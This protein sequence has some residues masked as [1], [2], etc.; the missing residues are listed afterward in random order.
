MQAYAREAL[1]AAAFGLQVPADRAR[2]RAISNL[3]AVSSASQ[4][5]G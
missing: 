4:M 2:E 1:A 5:T 3:K